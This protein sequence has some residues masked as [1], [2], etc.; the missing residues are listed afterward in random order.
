MTPYQ[1][2][3]VTICFIFKHLKKAIKNLLKLKKKTATRKLKFQMQNGLNFKNQHSRFHKIWYGLRKLIRMILIKLERSE[4]N[5][6][7]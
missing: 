3:R 1:P 5:N 2:F 4:I 7:I 6:F